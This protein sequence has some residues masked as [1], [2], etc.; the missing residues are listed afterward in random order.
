MDYDPKDHAFTVKQIIA[1]WIVCIGIV[2]L[3][4]GLACGHADGPAAAMAAGPSPRA[5]LMTP[6]P[7]RTLHGATFTG[8]PGSEGSRRIS[9]AQANGGPPSS[10]SRSCG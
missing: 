10:P 4:L 2:G 9:L 6:L 5:V 8:C 7:P 1:G 3:V